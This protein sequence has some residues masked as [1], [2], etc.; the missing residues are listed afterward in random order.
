[1]TRVVHYASTDSPDGTLWI[2]QSD[3][4]VVMLS[5]GRDELQFCFALERSGYEPEYDPEAVRTVVTELQ[6]FFAGARMRFDV[7]IDLTG[8]PRFQ[9]EVLRTVAQVPYGEVRSY[10]EIAEAVGRPRAARAVGTA[11]A[12][13]PVS[14]L[15]PCHRIIRSD[16]TLGEYGGRTAGGSGA[17]YKR[18]L[19]QREGVYL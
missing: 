4:G 1:M 8:L 17:A 13:N 3:G 15:I 5:I 7:P 18:L 14:F 11:L 2:A 9:R 16:G 12:G 6:E 19:L 10:R